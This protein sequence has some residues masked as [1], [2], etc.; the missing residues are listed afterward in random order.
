M[1]CLW[2]SS[3]Y[4]SRSSKPVRQVHAWPVVTGHERLRQQMA[5]RDDRLAAQLLP[6]QRR[7]LLEPPSLPQIEAVQEVARIKRQ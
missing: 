1:S 5:Q 4:G 3:L 6:L 7:P 2:A